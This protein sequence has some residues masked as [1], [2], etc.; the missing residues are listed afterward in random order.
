MNPTWRAGQEPAAV[1]ISVAGWFRVVLR[2]AGTIVVLI[3]GL[4][5]LLMLRFVERPIFGLKRPWTPAITMVVCRLSLLIMGL[6]LSVFG[7]PIAGS[8]AMVANHSSWLDILVLN[9][10]NR[11]FFVAKSEVAGWPGI[12]FLARATGTVFIR[13]RGRDARVHRNI[14]K[15]R[16]RAGQRLLFFPEGT[17]TDG[18]LVLPFKSTLFAA[19]FEPTLQPLF[20]IQPVT[21]VYRSPRDEQPGFYGWW[22]DM[23]LG[24]H[25]LQV[26]AA[27]RQG[28]VSLSYHAPLKLR[29][30]KDRKV[31]ALACEKS[32]RAGLVSG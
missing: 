5:L 28:T 3:S 17:S 20:G 16:L 19:F 2:G 7:T 8:G 21:V 6:R 29:D 9:A 30:F 31:L 24:P 27:R 32:V 18:S 11:I 1:S 25:L 10:C 22:G 15:A 26:L 13:R 4:V 14:V 12:G 23:A